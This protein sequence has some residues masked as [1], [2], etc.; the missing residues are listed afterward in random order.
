MQL[1]EYIGPFD[2]AATARKEAEKVWVIVYGKETL[3]N[4]KP[5]QVYYDSEN[6]VWLVKGTLPDGYVGGTA[7]I[8]FEK[9]TGKILAVWHEL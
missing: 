8:L 7:H 1:N 2:D 9:E 3:K 4:E 6:A 5:Y